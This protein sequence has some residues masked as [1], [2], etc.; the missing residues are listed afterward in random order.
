MTTA[1]DI[2]TGKPDCLHDGDTVLEAAKKLAELNSWAVPICDEQGRPTGMITGHDIVVKV[3]AQGKDP[4]QTT[5]GEVSRAEPA[6]VDVDDSIEE[7]AKRMVDNKIRRLAVMEEENLVGTIGPRDI[8][9]N[10][11]REEAGRF[12]EDMAGDLPGDDF[13]DPW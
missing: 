10:L 11:R 2:M 1:R 8:A 5:V 13:T 9:F 6:T 12:L 3:V 4:A 7:A